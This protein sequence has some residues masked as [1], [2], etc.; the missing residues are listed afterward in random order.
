MDRIQ[1]RHAT[2]LIMALFVL[3]P[4]AIGAWLSLIPH[5]KETLS[6][7]KGELALALL[8]MPLAL[9]PFLQLAARIVSAFGPR[10][11]FMVVFPIQSVMVLLPL[12][13]WSQSSLFFALGL[14]GASVAFLEVGLNAYAG[15]LEKRADLM[16]M[17]RCHGFWSLGIMAG[18]AI[19]ALTIGPPM[20]K[21]VALAV[22]TTLLGIWA[23]WALPRLPGDEEAAVPPRRRLRQLPKALFFIA[24]FMFSV[25]LT[26][27][28][29]ADWA[30]V[31]LA[32]RLGDLTVTERAGVA[33]TIFAAFMAGGRFLGDWLKAR[34]GAVTL[35]RLT[36]AAAMAG[37][38]VLVL[39]LPLGMAY[40]GFALVGF[41]VSAGYPLG[42]SA[43][44]ALDDRYESANIAMMATV[45]LGGFLVGPPVI[46]GIAEVAS[47][48]W[49]LAAL[50]PGL[51]LS[52]LLSRWLRPDSG[53]SL[54]GESPKA[55]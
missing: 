7:S 26:E 52:I 10:R 32:E 46:G 24:L 35:A 41:G 3:Q 30:A 14:F 5:V 1:A 51:A 49:G 27:G 9:I 29:M 50:L 42:V 40:V 12:L 34:L 45:A 21:L 44:A 28:A 18:S 31:Y 23:A 16:I 43:I 15:R 38:L 11:I 20:V 25:T 39:P 53:V 8:G 33:V 48:S 55:A 37:V 47:L 13:A 19:V 54:A 2:L 4:L 17:N 36:V 6:L 22:P